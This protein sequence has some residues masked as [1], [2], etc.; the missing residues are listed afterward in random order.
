M[1]PRAAGTWPSPI[2]PQRLVSGST[3]I[4]DALPDGDDVW[5]SE[6]RP[7]ERGR[8]AIV[9][10]HEGVASEVT[11]PE[12]NARTS[13]HEY[14]GGAWWVDRGTLYWVEFGDQRLRSMRPG[15]EPLLLTPEPEVKRGL[16]YADGRVSP[17][18]RWIV[19]IR[20]HHRDSGAPDNEVVAI[21]TDGSMRV[22]VLASGADFYSSPR[23]SPDG[24]TLVW[25]QWDHPNMPWDST[26]LWIA[27]FTDG[28]VDGAHR[29]TGNGDEAL[30][31]PEW[32]TD[33]RLVVVT[34]RTDWWN[35]YEVSLHDGSLTPITDIPHDI[36]EPHWEFGQSRHCEGVHVIAGET[37]DTLSTGMSLPY[38]AIWSL[39][40]SS[41]DHVFVGAAYDRDNEVCRVR[42]GEL[43]VLRAAPPLGIDPS[44]LPAPEFIT[45]PTTGGATAHALY[46]APANPGYTCLPGERPP[47]VVAIHGGPTSNAG[48]QLSLKHRFWT[49][50]GFGVVDVDYR[51]SSGYGRR[52]RNLLRGQWC[53]VDVDDAVA[54][55]RFLAD[56]GDVDAA[57]MVI[58]GGSAGG[59]TTLLAL[60]RS[61]AFAAGANYFGVADLEA[62]LTDD[63][64]FESRYTVQLIGPWPE[65][66]DV[67]RARSP[68][69]HVDSIAAPLVVLQGAADT[70]VPPRHSTAIV[71]AMRSRG[72]QVEYHEYEGEGHGFRGAAAITHSIATELD[73]YLRV[74]GLD[75]RADEG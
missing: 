75:S 11:P 18:G 46:Y 36:V 17:D 16:R 27:G 57:R 65:A 12:A 62:L 45:F 63:H 43:Q 74:F 51:G 32:H 69:S 2:D 68:L 54:A 15:G 7:A 13:V 26:E 38:T 22:N 19:C 59:S 4:A 37:A 52:Y 34:D 53:Q 23:L 70:V 33:G 42:N 35:L 31:Q 41:T 10:W 39:H 9:R 48:R 29:L 25:V 28:A 3:H 30:Q 40:G 47:L 8:T 20:E 1:E 14:G 55:A 71:E 60:A 58:R 21:A 44:C 6:S 5:W 64:K 49:T 66:G 72:L 24:S 61:R 50:R 67:Y 56:R 73:F